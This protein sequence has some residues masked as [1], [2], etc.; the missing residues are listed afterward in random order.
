MKKKKENDRI[1]KRNFDYLC[2]V[3]PLLEPKTVLPFAGAY[4]IGG[5]NYFKNEFGNKIHINQI[6]ELVPLCN[7]LIN[8]QD[9]IDQKVRSFTDQYFS[10]LGT[11]SQFAAKYL[12]SN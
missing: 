3:I 10:N 7:K 5:K 11:S 2:K 6:N 1:I 8:N 9:N 4:I 12:L